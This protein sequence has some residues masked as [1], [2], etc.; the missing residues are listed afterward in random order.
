MRYILFILAS[1]LVFSACGSAG[2]S[3]RGSTN[4]L[5]I[6]GNFIIE[7]GPDGQADTIYHT[8]GDFSFY[9]QDSAL[10]TQE[11]TK[12]KVYV[13]DFFFTTCQEIC[14]PMAGQMLRVNNA[15]GNNPDFMILSHSIDPTFDTVAVLKQYAE[16][17]NLADSTRWRFLTGNQTDVYELGEKKYMVTAHQDSTAPGGVL[18]SGHFL[19]VDKLGRIRGV[20]DGTDPDAVDQLIADIDLLL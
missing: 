18:H 12:G 5:P 6:Y 8:V 7:E 13:A 14:I 3:G 15:W 19:L 1:G 9:D 4:K 10:I 11:T 17:L 16:K 20:Y 2:E